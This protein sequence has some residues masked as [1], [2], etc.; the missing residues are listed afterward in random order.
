MRIISISHTHARN[1]P[2]PGRSN[3]IEEWSQDAKCAG[4]G[5]SLL[6][7][8]RDFGLTDVQIIVTRQYVCVYEGGGGVGG[9]GE[10][11]GG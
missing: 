3:H 1:F 11:R 5:D 7:T 6:G 4:Q 8:L 10:A 2:L 9:R